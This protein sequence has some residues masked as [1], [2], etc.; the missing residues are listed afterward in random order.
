MQIHK[1][2]QIELDLN[3]RQ[4]DLVE[5]SLRSGCPISPHR[6]IPSSVMTA[7]VEALPYN[8]LALSSSAT[9][10]SQ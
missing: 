8:A 6:H 7:P 3:D 4:V 10:T 2:L 9:E 1:D 5:E